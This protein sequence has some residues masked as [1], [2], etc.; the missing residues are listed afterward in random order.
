MSL[1]FVR[2]LDLFFESYIF[3]EAFLAKAHKYLNRYDS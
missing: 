1:D 3:G 2:F